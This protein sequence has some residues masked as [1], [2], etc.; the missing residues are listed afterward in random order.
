MDNVVGN[1]QYGKT[2]PYPVTNYPANSFYGASAAWLQP[3][4]PAQAAGKVDPN[5]SRHMV[6]VIGGAVV[7]GYILF[8]YNYNR[9]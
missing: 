5:E 2:A 9:S 1:T 4:K 6:I 8:N 3:S 7:L